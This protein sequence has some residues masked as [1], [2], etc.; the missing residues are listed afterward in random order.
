MCALAALALL[1]S[2][3]GSRLSDEE[4]ASVIS[5]M[6]SRGGGGGPT[7]DDGSPTTDGGPTDT[8]DDAPTTS[9]GPTG[10]GGGDPQG[11]PTGD[12]P[13]VAAGCAGRGGE[14]DTGVSANKLTVATLADITGVQ[15][16][17]FQSAHQ[18]ARA[19]AAYINS[20]GGI[21]GRALDPLLLDSKTDSGGN[22][23]AMLD[24]CDKAFAVVGSM[25]AFD[26]GSAAPGEACG[27][28][29]ISAIVTNAPKAAASNTYAI[30]PN[31]T[32]YVATTPAEY[33]AKRFP[34]EVKKSAQ[35]W[36]N[37]AV[38]KN[39][40]TER[41]RAWEKAGFNFIY[42]TETQ[43]LEANYTRFVQEM[44]S[45]GVQLATM[46]SDFQSLMRLQKAMRQQNYIPKV[47][48]WDSVAY[49][50]DYLAEPE[51]V[52]GSYV[53]INNAMFE[54]S[55][56]EKELYT[57]W[58]QR[59]SPGAVPDYFG[60]YAWSAYRLFQNLATKLGKDLKRPKLMAALKATKTWGA[61]GLH[62]PHQIGAKRISVCNLWL[63][64]KGGKFTRLDP[65]SGFDCTGELVKTR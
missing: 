30:A 63:Q 48:A 42:Q 50:G 4:R 15:P 25:S 56:P 16:G 18:A 40:A 6:T 1:A 65:K 8:G 60:L 49:D 20:E 9:G 52:E 47:R 54:E 13:T 46:V 11:G 34:N 57:D 35:L 61:N 53:F 12:G 45:R 32:G 24:A 38:T 64:V 43:V 3:C 36:L 55:N 31:A 39:N 10:N 5:A 17:L 19:A 41:M 59:V 37:Q 2:G 22:R 28:P 51:V 33:L 21:C 26:D 23:A 29:D 44:R 14:T 7:T 27:I 58:L 62:A